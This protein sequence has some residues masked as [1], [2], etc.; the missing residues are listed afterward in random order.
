MTPLVPFLRKRPQCE[1]IFYKSTEKSGGEIPSVSAAER[2]SFSSFS[3][4]HTAESSR[5]QNFVGSQTSWVSLLTKPLALLQFVPCFLWFLSMSLIKKLVP[6]SGFPPPFSERTAATPLK[7]TLTKMFVPLL[8][9]TDV[10]QW[11][12]CTSFIVKVDAVNLLQQQS[13]SEHFCSTFGNPGVCS[14][15]APVA[16]RGIPSS[17]WYYFHLPWR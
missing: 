5:R 6:Y 2:P 10:T 11:G 16:Q 4:L 1:L 13:E 7:H 17:L 8:S 12:D 14:L 9:L 15:K 3:L